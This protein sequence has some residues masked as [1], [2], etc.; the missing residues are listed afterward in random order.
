[1]NAADVVG[2]TFNGAAYC[3]DC[4]GE[5]ENAWELDAPEVGAIF[6]GS[7]WDCYPTCDACLATIDDV[8]LVS[9]TCKCGYVGP[10]VQH[11]GNPDKCLA[12]ERLSLMGK[13]WRGQR[14]LGREGISKECDPASLDRYA[15]PGGYPIV[16]YTRR[17]DC[18]CAVC[19]LKALRDPDTYD[20]DL[21]SICDAY[22]EHRLRRVWGDLRARKL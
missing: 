2:Y 11:T 21:P 9:Y 22:Y 6:A 14:T 8:A 1:M 5:G 3:L 18:L 12:C 20:G 7:E 19:T 4:A 17:E 15:W 16:Y 10:H 13:G